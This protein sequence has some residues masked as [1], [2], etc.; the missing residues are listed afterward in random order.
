MLLSE[1]QNKEI[2]DITS[3]KKIGLIIDV[4]VSQ[5]GQIE[6]LILEERKLGRRFKYDNKGELTL[7]WTKIM[8]IGDDIILVDMNR[9]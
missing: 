9:H 5:S 2:I 7:P 6:S 4:R 1:L 3:G 8:K